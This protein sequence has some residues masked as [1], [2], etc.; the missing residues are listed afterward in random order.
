MLKTMFAVNF[1]TAPIGSTSQIKDKLLL[2]SGDGDSNLG[3]PDLFVIPSKDLRDKVVLLAPSDDILQAELTAQ[4]P[5]IGKHLIC[6]LNVQATVTTMRI[7]PYPHYLGLDGLHQDISA[8]DMYERLL[9]STF[10]SPMIQHAMDFCRAAVVGPLRQTD[11]KGYVDQSVWYNMPPAEA[12]RWRKQA[13]ESFFPSLFPPLAGTILPPP[14]PPAPTAPAPAPIMAPPPAPHTGP[15]AFSPAVAAAAA[16]QAAISSSPLNFNEELMKALVLS[17]QAQAQN[18]SHRPFSFQEEKKSEEPESMLNKISA[19]EATLMRTLC[20]LPPNVDESHF[21]TWYT[22]LFNKNQSKNDKDMIIA[23]AL[24]SGLKFQDARI[25]IYP[26]LKTM[27]RDR[28]WTGGEAGGDPMYSHACFGL[29][30]FAMLDLSET[31]KAQMEFMA[32]YL[33]GATHITTADIKSTK[34]KLIA[35]VPEN[36]TKWRNMLLQY[37]NL[38]LNLFHADSRMY[39]RM[40]QLCKALHR[41]DISILD[42]LSITAKASILWIVHL[43]SRHYAQGKMYPN[44]PE[45]ELLPAFEFMINEIQAGKIHQVSHAGVPAPL[46]ANSIDKR[47]GDKDPLDNRDPK[48][49]KLT[50]GSEKDKVQAPWNEKLKKLLAAPLRKANNPSLKQ[51]CRYCKLPENDPVVKAETNQCRAYLLFGKC[52]FG[53]TCRFSHDTA[54]EDQADAILEKFQPFLNSPEELGKT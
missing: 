37:T 49:L 8:M 47:K 16:A 27:I 26:E 12:K 36:G 13:C 43:Q 9:M 46:L 14:P 38:L 34:T 10:R 39:V 32:Q 22:H 44:N 29:T 20:G 1:G 24:T 11:K 18:Q 5:T 40:A 19:H 17:L 52:R 54:T 48:K 33:Q 3:P 28:T 53:K 4:S 30:V 51:I 42:A 41:Y 35:K 50:P 31:D 21:P 25:P 15:P 45:G 6:P 7:A 23:E 2:L